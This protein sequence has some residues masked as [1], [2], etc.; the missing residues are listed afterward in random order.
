M[1]IAG[2]IGF[3]ALRHG[4]GP[5]PFVMGLVLGGLVERSWSQAMI[6]FD[7][8][9]WRFFESP[10]CNLFFALTVLS[11]LGPYLGRGLSAIVRRIHPKLRSPMEE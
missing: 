7:S 2:L 10:I 4:F 1:L 3:L 11:L 8:A 5:A 9:W 6:I